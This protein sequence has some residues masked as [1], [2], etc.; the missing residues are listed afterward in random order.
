MIVVEESKELSELIRII[1]SSPFTD[2]LSLATSSSVVFSDIFSIAFVEKTE[3]TV[4]DDDV[5]GNSLT[6]S[7]LIISGWIIDG[8][9][10]GI[11]NVSE[12]FTSI[13]SSFWSIFGKDGFLI[14]N[15]IGS[16]LIGSSIVASVVG[17]IVIAVNV[18]SKTSGGIS[19]ISLLLIGTIGLRDFGTV[20]CDWIFSDRKFGNWC[21]FCFC[22][23]GW[24]VVHI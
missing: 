23:S 2:A 6:T 8:G 24:G 18:K 14:G 10:T 21:W 16:V 20:N 1:C 12:S 4:V 22:T 13:F 3:I 17:T 19:A 11:L 5:C 7:G 15:K 9:G